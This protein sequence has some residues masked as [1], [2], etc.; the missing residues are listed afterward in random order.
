MMPGRAIL[1]GTALLAAVEPRRIS[2]RQTRL[3]AI[4]P[5]EM[6]RRAAR[7]AYPPYKTFQEIVGRE[8]PQGFAPS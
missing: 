4:S 7:W 2:V 3:E 1:A 6:L 8:C 5:I